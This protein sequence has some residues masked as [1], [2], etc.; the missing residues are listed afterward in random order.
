[1]R[2]T[3]GVG[4]VLVVVALVAS[5]CVLN[6]SWAAMTPAA[7]PAPPPGVTSDP[8][9]SDVSC[10]EVDWCLAVGA[11]VGDDYSNWVPLAQVWDGSAWTT[12]DTAGLLGPDSP[13]D[14]IFTERLD[15]VACR[16]SNDCVVTLDQLIEADGSGDIY[17]RVFTWDGTDWT[18]AEFD[19]LEPEAPKDVDCAVGGVCLVWEQDLGGYAFWDGSTWS[20]DDWTF[21]DGPGSCFGPDFCVRNGQWAAFMEHWDGTEWTSVDFPAENFVASAIDCT[22]ATR[23]LAV[24]IDDPD[25]DASG[26]LASAR[27]NGTEWSME[28]VAV[29]GEGTF[30]GLSCASSAECVA[31]GTTGSGRETVAWNGKD[32]YEIAGPPGGL[33]TIYE[34]LSCAGLSCVAVGWSFPPETSSLRAAEYAWTRD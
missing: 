25:F 26:P 5:A 6:G 15:H 3:L 21:A 7:P 27:W 17:G 32:W 22:S 24:G 2:R 16:A 31:L 30:D 1:V 11:V 20:G 14:I 4:A 18:R 13:P 10:P 28:P 19:A 23:C 9:F 12:V 8:D 34:D 33:S 29:A